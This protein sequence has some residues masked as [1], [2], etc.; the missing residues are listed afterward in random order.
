M[1]YIFHIV[2]HNERWDDIAYKYYGNCYNIK[3][4]IEAN[5]HLKIES[6]L[7]EGVEIIIPVDESVKNDTSLL[8]PWKTAVGAGGENGQFLP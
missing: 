5:P 7:R 4:I 6:I 2:G 1:K 8:P 3:P